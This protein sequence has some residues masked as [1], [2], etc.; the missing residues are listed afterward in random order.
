MSKSIIEKLGITPGPWKGL[1]GDGIDRRCNKHIYAT[2]PFGQICIIDKTVDD[3][4]NSR[5]IAAA[6]EMLEALIML[7][8]SCEHDWPSVFKNITREIIQKATGKTWAEIK[9]LYDTP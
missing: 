9:E 7:K 8:T 5:I 2:E 3:L 1:H 6:P 4:A